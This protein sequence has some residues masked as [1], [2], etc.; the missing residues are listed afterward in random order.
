M[1]TKTQLSKQKKLRK[2]KILA[3]DEH[4][5]HEENLTTDERIALE[6]YT[7]TRK[8]KKNNICEDEEDDNRSESDVYLGQNTP[9]PDYN[10]A[11]SADIQEDE[12][13]REQ[14]SRHIVGLQ[15]WALGKGVIQKFEKIDLQ[16]RQHYYR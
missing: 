10:A 2:L 1:S 7:A 9:A 3:A 11:E 15:M 8:G 16:N 12:D 4:K 6:L 14:R 13:D 5:K